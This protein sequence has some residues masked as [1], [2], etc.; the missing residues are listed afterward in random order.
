M[1]ESTILRWTNYSCINKPSDV[2]FINQSKITYDE[3]VLMFLF[4]AILNAVIHLTVWCLGTYI[5]E[6]HCLQM[7]GLKTNC[8]TKTKATIAVK[9]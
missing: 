6:Y 2:C 7:H 1:N 4:I 9:N 3:S 5:Q 8:S